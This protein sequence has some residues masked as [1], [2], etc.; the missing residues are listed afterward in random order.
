MTQEPKFPEVVVQL[1]GEDGNAFVIIGA[2]R[3]AMRLAGV[4]DE[5]VEAYTNAAMEGDYNQLL[6]VTMQTVTVE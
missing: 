4:S 3:K 1:T 2:V 5:D 6:R